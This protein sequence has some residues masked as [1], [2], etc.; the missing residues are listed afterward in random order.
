MKKIN[1]DKIG[2]KTQTLKGFRDLPAGRQV[3][4]QKGTYE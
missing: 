4:C 2:V 1:P 3:F